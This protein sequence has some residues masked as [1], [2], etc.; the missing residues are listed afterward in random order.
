MFLKIKKNL[1]GAI[2]KHLDQ[3]KE[4]NCMKDNH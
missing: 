2:L 1:M 4:S 3:A